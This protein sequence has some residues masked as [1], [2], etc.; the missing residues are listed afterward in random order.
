M[1]ITHF[2]AAT[3]ALTAFA[4]ASCTPAPQPASS[5]SA[6][7]AGPPSIAAADA[8]APAA[9]S[10][11]AT[12]PAALP[13]PATPAPRQPMNVILLIVDALRWDMPWD[14]YPRDVAPNLKKLRERS[15]RY[16][17]GY[18]ISSFTSKSVAGLLS[19]KFP[20]ELERTTP[21]FTHYA[22]SN[23]MMA[24]VLQKAGVKTLSA[25]AHMYL[26][27]DSGLT[28]GFD[29]W[30]LVSGIQFDYNKD[31]YITSPRYT[32]LL[33]NILSKPENTSG[34]FFAYFHYM[35]PH[36]E[37]NSHPES[38]QWGN[39]ARDLYDQEVWFTDMWIQ[40][41]LDF[42]GSQPWGSNTAIIVTGDHG[43][44]FGE[45]IGGVKQYRV[46]K[47]AFELYEV[48]VR[49]PLFI[50]V[51]GAEPKDVPRW[52]SQIDLVPTIYDLLGVE[53]SAGLFGTSLVPELLGD[54]QPQ[55][56]IVV[57]LPA[58]V[59]NQRHRVLIEDGYKLISFGRDF[60][61]TMF[62]VREDP[63]ESKELSRADKPRKEQMINRYKEVVGRIH[64]VDA[65][66][67]APVKP[68]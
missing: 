42:V 22:D 35:D 53:A 19:G 48:L 8:P 34:R 54:A 29:V 21:F 7:T 68:D 56:P 33:T 40:K 59:Y 51:P 41:F 2:A 62:N 45:R 58:D 65:K 13:P 16:E 23:E 24:E 9:S 63:W 10:S 39:G 47:H 26:D 6:A 55:R 66:G 43:E 44:G 50:Y 28:Q 49:V 14:G 61:Y 67:G 37:Y 30:K 1:R 18:S 64:D 4:W 12:Q 11:S 17:R 52:R 20:S 38:P 5:P 36:H 27:K 60:R 3:I 32:E 15:V 25:H 57:D 46:W 31:P